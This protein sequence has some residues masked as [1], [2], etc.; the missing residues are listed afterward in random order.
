MA[1]LVF[2][3][4][5]Q[6]LLLITPA[7]AAFSPSKCINA[8]GVAAP[9][10]P[11]N[12]DCDAARPW[13]PAPRYHV[14]DL[15]CAEND[16]NAPVYDPKHGVYHLMYQDHVGLNGNKPPTFGHVVSRDLVH[17]A[18]LPVAVWNGP[19]AYDAQAINQCYILNL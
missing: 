3:T 14:Q 11:G 1:A 5:L 12:S 6:A 13:S 17:W 8:A 4:V 7:T 2:A 9:C 18:R 16:P 19:E 15:S 10:G